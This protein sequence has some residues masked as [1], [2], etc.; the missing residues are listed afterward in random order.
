MLE[1]NEFGNDQ[2]ILIYNIIYLL[3]SICQRRTICEHELKKN[4]KN[5]EY[6]QIPLYGAYLKSWNC[7]GIFATGSSSHCEFS[8]SKF[9]IIPLKKLPKSGPAKEKFL[10]QIEHPLQIPNLEPL[11]TSTF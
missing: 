8:N 2:K 4:R 9:E 5:I 3:L 1:K 7:I 11:R 10:S 6:R